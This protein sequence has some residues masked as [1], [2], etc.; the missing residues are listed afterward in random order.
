LKKEEGLV[1]ETADCDMTGLS[2]F[3]QAAIDGD[4]AQSPPFPPH[5]TLAANAACRRL[6]NN[7]VLLMLLPCVLEIKVGGLNEANTVTVW[8]S[9]D[10]LFHYDIYLRGVLFGKPAGFWKNWRP[11]SC[12]SMLSS[13]FAR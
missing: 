5:L 11:Y 4:T 12:V 6:N 2:F 10:N 3:L 1:T 8:S 13:L 9:I 7:R